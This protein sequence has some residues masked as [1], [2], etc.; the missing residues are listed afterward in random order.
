[1]RCEALSKLDNGIIFIPVV[2]QVLLIAII[3]AVYWRSGKCVQL[4]HLP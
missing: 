1:M 3:T 4:L 2:L